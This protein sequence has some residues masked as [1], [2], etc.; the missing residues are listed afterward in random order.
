M[1]IDH[2]LFCTFR[3]S[4]RLFGIELQDIKEIASETNCT[5]VPH[6]PKSVRGLVN[7]RGTIV[8]AIDL[9]RLLDLPTKEI[10]KSSAG[11]LV[12]FKAKIGASFGLLVDSI[13]EIV[14]ISNSDFTK[15][16]DHQ[17]DPLINDE[18]NLI[19]R[20]CRLP[21]ELLLTLDPKRFLT[22][23][24]KQLVAVNDSPEKFHEES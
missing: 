7:I 1:S 14:S 24:D 20:I 22:Q 6:A 12:I 16:T 13:D 15:T 2:R 19:G 8:L 17:D 23:L 5:Y 21:G 11:C 9:R 4:G 10:G 18:H 3:T